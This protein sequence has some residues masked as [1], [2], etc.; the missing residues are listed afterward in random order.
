[1]PHLP[2]SMENVEKWNNFIIQSKNICIEKL[3]MNAAHM[4]K[5]YP[6]KFYEFLQILIDL[7]LIDISSL[8]KELS[9]ECLKHTLDKLNQILDPNNPTE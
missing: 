9:T 4:S 6:E 8:P 7:K 5:V 1:M 3:R 2:Y